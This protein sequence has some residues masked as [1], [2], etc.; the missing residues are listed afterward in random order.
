MHIHHEAVIS[1]WASNAS[2]YDKRQGVLRESFVYPIFP[3]L[4]AMLLCRWIVFADVIV[5]RA[6]RSWFVQLRAELLEFFPT[7]DLFV[8]VYFSRVM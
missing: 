4:L 5:R 6:T 8:W 1:S 3:A 7:H 2:S